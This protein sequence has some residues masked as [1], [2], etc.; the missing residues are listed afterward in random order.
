MLNDETYYSKMK[1]FT[2]QVLNRK[3]VSIVFQP[4]RVKL[5]NLT[6]HSIFIDIS[7]ARSLWEHEMKFINH[8]AIGRKIKRIYLQI[9]HFNGLGLFKLDY[10]FIFSV[11]I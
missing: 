10:T 6:C 11:N 4:E 8:A 9:F 2:L 3:K 1:S 5:F 7:L